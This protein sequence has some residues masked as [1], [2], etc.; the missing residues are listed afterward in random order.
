MTES[1]PVLT[2][3]AIASTFAFQTGTALLDSNEFRVV[4]GSLPYL[5]L[6][7][8]ILLLQLINYHNS[9]TVVL[10][11]IGMLWGIY[12][13]IYMVRKIM[14]LFFIENSLYPSMH[15]PMLIR[16]GIRM[17]T[18]LLVP[19]LCILAVIH[20][21]RV[22]RSNSLSLIHPVKLNTNPLL[23]LLLNLIRYILFFLNLVSPFLKHLWSIVIMLVRPISA[24]TLSSTPTWSMLF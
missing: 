4:V 19:T 17:I 2:P 11:I 3:L 6:R 20:S 5:S 16:L 13:D 24:P 9:D 22:P 1:K 12:C 18:L 14:V 7:I 15:S 21:H 10:L 23:P 8:L